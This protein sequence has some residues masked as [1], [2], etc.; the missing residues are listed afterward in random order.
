MQPE[1]NF[2]AGVQRG[3]GKTGDLAKC[4][5]IFRRRGHL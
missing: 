4:L 5:L 2:L 3:S 1:R